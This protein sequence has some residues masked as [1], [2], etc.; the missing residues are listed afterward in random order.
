MNSTA[1]IAH[2]AHTP[3]ITIQVLMLFPRNRAAAVGRKMR[4]RTGAHGPYIG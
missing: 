1:Q 3:V 4:R 2:I